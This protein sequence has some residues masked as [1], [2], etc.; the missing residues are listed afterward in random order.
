MY[1][2]ES[3]LKGLKSYCTIIGVDFYVENVLFFCIN[4]IRSVPQ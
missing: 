3:D 2:L 1:Y 4:A